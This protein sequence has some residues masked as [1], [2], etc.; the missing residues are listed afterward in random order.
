[1][2]SLSNELHSP[3]VGICVLKEETDICK[4]CARTASEIEDWG[5]MSET[6]LKS[7]WDRIATRR[8]ESGLG[9]SM[10]ALSKRQLAETLD[11]ALDN[12]DA[13][14]TA[15]GYGALAEFSHTEDEPFERFQLKNGFGAETKKGA[16]AFRPLASFKGFQFDQQLALAVHAKRAAVSRNGTI[17]ELGPDQ[18]VLMSDSSGGVLFD[19]GL[20]L[21]HIDFC[22]RTNDQNLIS[23]LRKAVGHNIFSENTEV[24]DILKKAQPERVIVSQLARIEVGQEIPQEDGETPK[25]PHTHILPELLAHKC[26]HPPESPL[27]KTYFPGITL[28]GVV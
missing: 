28:Y 3:C 4:G 1:M 21:Y 16:I 17:Q 19:L 15:G 13:V 27:P 10:A 5:G 9:Y 25:G 18:C 2:D 6:E 8:A 14:F 12:P 26:A 22:I 11:K 20:G 24:W 7:A 23:H